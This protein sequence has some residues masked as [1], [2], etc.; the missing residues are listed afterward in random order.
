MKKMTKWMLP[1]CALL[2]VVGV[3]GCDFSQVKGLLSA[4][5]IQD[6]VGTLLTSVVGGA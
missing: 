5:P 6:L 4:A 1:V 3:V 2:L